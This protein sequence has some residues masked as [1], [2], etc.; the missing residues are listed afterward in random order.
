MRNNFSTDRI[1]LRA[2]EPEDLELMFSLENEE[3]ACNA[4]VV[5]I[6]INRKFW[7]F[8]Q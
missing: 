4:S 3:D 5:I 2:P 7:L 6:I 8:L 1:L